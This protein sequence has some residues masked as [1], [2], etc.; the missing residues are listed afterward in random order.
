[1]LRANPGG[2][3]APDDVVG[4]DRLIQQLW[5]TL[6]RQS[7]V[8]VAERRMGKTSVA[9]KM[10]AEQQNETLLVLY[11]DVESV[12]TPIGFVERIYQDIE[13]HLSLT[14]RG[15]T[16]SHQILQQLSG[17]EISGVGKL[18]DTAAKHWKALLEEMFSNLVDD[19]ERTVLFFWDEFPLMLQKIVKSSGET[20]A[21]EVLDALRAARQT[22]KQLR[23]LYTGS[24]GLH[25]VTKALHRAGHRNDATNDMRSV[26]VEPLK[27][28]DAQSLA[29]ALLEGEELRCTDTELVAKEIATATDSIAFYI[30]YV[31]SEMKFA[32]DTASVELAKSIVASAMVA[33]H[34][35][36]HLQHYRSRL[37]EY[38]GS[39]QLKVVLFLLDILATTSIPLSIKDLSN[40]LSSSSEMMGDPVGIQ[41]TSGD[42]ELIRTIL[43][44]LLR[45]HYLQ[46]QKTDGCYSF[47]FQ[48]IQRWWVIS[49][50]LT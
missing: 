18:P 1:M 10:L 31:V 25:H 50:G 6:E 28:T 42:A 16:G 27:L 49:R 2:E 26:E 22:H 19:Q 47:R 38:F 11:R 17:A 7:V 34:D 41:I 43:T 15:K 32:G 35:P 33:S 46:R 48:I 4:R 29:V 14:S 39:E 3:I 21:M 12:D 13:C 24:I 20:A 44:Q 45:D 36:W 8:L 37:D 23:M 9:K 30:H 5:Q 40:L